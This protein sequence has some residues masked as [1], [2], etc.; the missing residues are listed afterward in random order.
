MT[1][2]PPLTPAAQQ[3][4]A[5]ARWQEGRRIQLTGPP[6]LSC[7]HILRPPVREA[8]FTGVSCRPSAALA[9][10]LLLLLLNLRQTAAAAPATQTQTQN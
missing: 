5:G 2:S 6:P 7:W 3:A 9:L 10:L 8:N 1:G 4:P